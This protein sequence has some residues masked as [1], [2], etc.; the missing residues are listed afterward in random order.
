MSVVQ[1]ILPI[2]IVGVTET[3]LIVQYSQEKK[4]VHTILQKKVMSMLLAIYYSNHVNNGN[5]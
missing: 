5:G 2:P 4:N 1:H 3:I